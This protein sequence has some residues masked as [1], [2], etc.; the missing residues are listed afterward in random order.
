MSGRGIHLQRFN[1]RCRITLRDRAGFSLVELMVVITIVGLLAGMV[2][3]RLSGMTGKARFQQAIERLQS[4]DDGLR[5]RAVRFDQPC[6][7]QLTIGSSRIQRVYGNQRDGVSDPV[8]SGNVEI[9]RVRSP[10]RDVGTGNMTVHYAATGTSDSWAV[11]LTAPGHEPRWLL[12]AGLTGQTTELER[13][14]DVEDILEASQPPR[15]D[16]R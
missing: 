4:V 6:E 1:G 2:S 10:T 16:A 8:L 12:F 5:A 14:R 13:E 15:S 11:Q 7:L 9:T 3:L